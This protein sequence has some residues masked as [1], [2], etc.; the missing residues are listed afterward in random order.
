[1]E[2]EREGVDK[3]NEQ[4]GILDKVI[5]VFFVFVIFL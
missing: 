4:N 3:A 2:R 1:M 5:Q